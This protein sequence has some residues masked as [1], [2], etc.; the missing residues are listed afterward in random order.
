[1]SLQTCED[2]STFL[3]AIAAPV[4]VVDQD[5]VIKGANREAQKGLKKKLLPMAGSQLGTVFECAHS[6]L[7]GGCGRTI[8]CNG[9]SIRLAIAKTLKT[10]K[11]QS[12]VPSYLN[13]RKDEAVKKV[14]FHIS[15]QKVGRLIFLKIEDA[16][17]D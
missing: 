9:C 12:Q 4:V 13:R 17:G 3:D 1:M 2:L 10:G 14:R 5:A 6:E 8:H 7:P 11:S 16:P 15:T